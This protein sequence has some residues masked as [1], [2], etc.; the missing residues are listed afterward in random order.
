VE[1]S[2]VDSFSDADA[3]EPPRWE[4]PPRRRVDTRTPYNLRAHWSRLD[5]EPRPP[6]VP[7]AGPRGPGG[8]W[9][10]PL[11]RGGPCSA[12]AMGCR[13]V[14][15]MLKLCSAGQGGLAKTAE[16]CVVLDAFS[17]RP[18]DHALSWLMSCA[19]AVGAWIGNGSA[20]QSE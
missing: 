20:G 17:Q 13:S 2:P 1:W 7:R 16:G 10:H 8:R 5:V 3:S 15:L 19:S 11:A 14:Q 6:A 18:A 4:N 9:V 12:P